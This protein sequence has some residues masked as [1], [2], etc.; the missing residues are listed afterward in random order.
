MGKKEFKKWSKWVKRAAAHQHRSA[1]AY[2]R[3]AA[4]A[5]GAGETPGVSTETG[6]PPIPEFP[7][8]F[9]AVASQ[10]QEFLNYF[11]MSLLLHLL[12]N[13]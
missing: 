8:D 13:P 10:I 1:E 6:A 9:Q 12:T 2:A 3:A 11:G 7:V 4:A 5:G